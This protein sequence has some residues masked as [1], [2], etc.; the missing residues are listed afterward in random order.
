M[1]L[2][3][4]KLESENITIQK[5]AILS[6]SQTLDVTFVAVIISTFSR[7]ELRETCY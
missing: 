6:A 1:I 4:L 3:L 7:K 2:F 5:A